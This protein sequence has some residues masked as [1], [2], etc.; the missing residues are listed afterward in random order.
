[1]AKMDGLDNRFSGTLE[2]LVEV[3]HRYSKDGSS[4]M[5][6]TLAAMKKAC[7]KGKSSMPHPLAVWSGKLSL[8]DQEVHFPVKSKLP[9]K[10]AKVCCRV[11]LVQP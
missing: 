1:M 2:S 7:K 9:K 3:F 4:S 5:A 8:E 11:R 6:D 10:N